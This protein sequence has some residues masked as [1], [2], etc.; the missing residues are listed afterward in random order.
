MCH[1][2]GKYIDSSRLYK[3]F[4]HCGIYGHEVVQKILEG[5]NTKICIDAFLIIYSSLFEL[6]L[7]K[8]YKILP[9]MKK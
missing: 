8:F 5:K 7:R 4:T 1:A 2:I 6:L 9:E 3:P